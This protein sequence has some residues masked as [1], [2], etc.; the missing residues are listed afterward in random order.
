M[1]DIKNEKEDARQWFLRINGETVFGPVSTQGLIVWAEQGRVLPGHEVSTDRKKWDQAV[2]ID[3]LDMRWFVDDGEGE[4]RGP[5]NKLAA[6]A[7]IK[8]G[9][10]PKGAQLVSADEVETDSGSE[11]TAEPKRDE[12]PPPRELVP[13]EVLRQRVRELE[14]M[15]SEQRDRLVKLSDADAYETVQHERDVLASL[16]KETETQRATILRNAEKDARAH[17]RKLELLRQQIKK[18]EQQLE[19]ANSRLMMSEAHAAEGPDQVSKLESERMA[20]EARREVEERARR[21][22]EE[23]EA[24]LKREAEMLRSKLAASE[25]ALSDLR[26][27]GTTLQVSLSEETDALKVRVS[28]LEQAVELQKQTAKDAALALAARESELETARERVAACTRRASQAESD[29]RESEEAGARL[30]A[31]REAELEKER[32]RAKEL[33]QQLGQ[34]QASA[35]DAEAKA[36]EHEVAFTELLNDANARDNT[37]QEKI[38]ALEKTC[39]QS[40]DETARFFADQAAVY[41]LVK[42]EIEELSQTMEMERT[43]VAQLKEWSAQRQQALQERR[44]TLMK[45]MGGSPVEMTRRTVREQPSDPQTARLRAELENQRVMYQREVELAETQ[46]REFQDKVR[47]LELE[48]SRLQHQTAEGEKRI[49]RVEELEELLSRSDH[50]LSDERRNREA[51]REQFTANQ[52]ALLMRIET[53]ER[54]GRPSTPEEIQSA[55]A[56]NVKLAS[57]MRL[58]R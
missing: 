10:V 30:L 43:H 16:V 54:T 31:T 28:E 57:W 1:A 48:C 23:R 3:L 45:H 52:K 34:A 37:Y 2:S 41:E 25:Q 9:K 33:E 19:D 12:K 21:E 20:E 18:L 46:N 29:L 5:L 27:A 11:K 13:E 15:V 40:P 35:R 50:E 36:R 22:S 56:Q 51:E 4:L 47:L 32:A 58:R 44:Q 26:A 17:E 7:L 14:T 39:A 53:L 55:E 49:R 38:L 6:E 24:V 8:S 42:K